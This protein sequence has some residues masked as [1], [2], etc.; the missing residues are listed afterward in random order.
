[1]ANRTAYSYIRFSDPKQ[2]KSAS[3]DRQRDLSTHLAKKNN[4]HLNTTL[5]IADLGRSAYKGF[6]KGLHAFL[7]AV[8]E[9]QVEDG[10]ILIVEK[11]DRLTRADIDAGGELFKNILRAGVDIAT[12]QPEKIYTAADLKSLAVGIEIM[13]T[14]YVNWEHSQKLSDRL[15]DKWNRRREAGKRNGGQ[16]PA[17]I[18][19]ENGQPKLDKKKAK[20]IRQIYAWAI[21]G[22]GERVITKKLNRSG[23]PNIAAGLKINAAKFWNGSYVKSILDNKATF[24]LHQHYKM[25]LDPKTDMVDRVPVGQPIKDWWPACISEETWYAAKAARRARNRPRGQVGKQITN[26]FSGI[27]FD[28]KSGCGMRVVNSSQNDKA[29]GIHRRLANYNATEGAADYQSWPLCQFENLFL[30]GLKSEISTNKLLA[31]KPRKSN[32]P[33]LQEKLA[34]I[35]TNISDLQTRIRKRGFKSGLDLLEQ[36]DTDR[37]LL[38]E[39]IENEKE[40]LQKIKADPTENVVSVIDLLQKTPAEQQEETREKLKSLI[41]Q[42]VERIEILMLDLDG[43]RL[44]KHLDVFVQLK[45]GGTFSLGC[46]SWK[47]NIIETLPAIKMRN[48]WLSNSRAR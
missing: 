45:A 29:K 35:E 33:A 42:V 5:K 13:V 3:E 26:L 2:K 38:L 16:H 28:A 12:C 1:M 25:M 11:L 34:D 27:I 6:R 44:K 18:K 46:Q 20:V 21:E 41:A 40:R 23:T 43:N 30:D 8:E 39:E 10:S 36:L 14:L 48:V 37:S 15:N 4:W 47:G 17:W 9:G 24:G 32:L 22:L 7:K 19:M 31:P